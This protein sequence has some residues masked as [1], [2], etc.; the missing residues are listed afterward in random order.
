MPKVPASKKRVPPS[1]L[2]SGA[3][4][5]GGKASGAGVKKEVSFARAGDGLADGDVTISNVTKTED[6]CLQLGKVPPL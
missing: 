1:R 2:R 6:G 3:A 5:R 4:G